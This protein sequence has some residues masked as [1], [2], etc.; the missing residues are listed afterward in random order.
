MAV[1]GQHRNLEGDTG[2]SIAINF[3]ETLTSCQWQGQ[4]SDT[5]SLTPENYHFFT[6]KKHFHSL[7]L[8]ASPLH[9]REQVH[10]Q[11]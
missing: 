1:K 2:Q 8:R 3:A 4:H 7:G 5:K 6:V 9:Y 10:D 11:Y